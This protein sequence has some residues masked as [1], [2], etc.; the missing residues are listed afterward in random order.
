MALESAIL[1]LPRWILKHIKVKSHCSDSFL[2]CSSLYFQEVMYIFI[3]LVTLTCCVCPTSHLQ[4]TLKDSPLFKDLSW[5]LSNRV[6]S[7]CCQQPLLWS[8]TL[9]GGR[10]MNSEFQTLNSYLSA[11]HYLTQQGTLPLSQFPSHSMP[12]TRQCQLWY[13]AFLDLSFSGTHI[14]YC[15]Y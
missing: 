15:L 6:S 11:P 8:P 13:D 10:E 7:Q 12:S 4:K 2:S 9:S 3:S 1:R 5:C 14:M